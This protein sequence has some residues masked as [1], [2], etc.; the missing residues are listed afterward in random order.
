MRFGFDYKIGVIFAQNS[1]QNI[2]CGCSLESD[3]WG[4]TDEWLVCVG[5]GTDKTLF[6]KYEESH[7]VSRSTI[8][9]LYPCE[10]VLLSTLSDQSL[11]KNM[12][13]IV[14]TCETSIV[15]SHMSGIYIKRQLY[16]SVN[17][18]FL[19]GNLLVNCFQGQQLSCS[20]FCLT[21]PR[22]STLEKN[23]LPRRK[24]FSQ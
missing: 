21:S 16:Q 20:H 15:M 5:V 23:M 17:L 13:C 8:N 11:L 22:V 6:Q 10:I 19:H 3:C 9:A 7:S 4:G 18:I 14:F 12:F 1:I 24:F 2:C